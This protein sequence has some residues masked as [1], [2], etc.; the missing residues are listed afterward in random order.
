MSWQAYLGLYVILGFV[1]ARFLQKKAADSVEKDKLLVHQFLFSAILAFGFFLYAGGSFDQLWHPL[2]PAVMGLGVLNGAANHFHWKALRISL[3]KT[4]VL[5][6]FDDISA[7]AL[8]FVFLGEFRLLREPRLLLG[9][10]LCFGSAWL[11][12][13]TRQEITA[14]HNRA[15]LTNVLSYSLLWGTTS[16]AMRALALAGLPIITFLVVWY[17]VSLLTVGVIMALTNR[18]WPGLRVPLNE[19]LWAYGAGIAIFVCMALMYTVRAIAPVTVTQPIILVSEMIIPFAIGW[20]AF[21][22][23]KAFSIIEKLAVLVGFAGGL[24]L[25]FAY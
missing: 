8:S 5:T 20:Y 23:G 19:A 7:I 12:I 2:V 6:Q 25:A 15:L 17:S 21:R 18:G 9:M 13:K 22:E 3:S 11:F 16:C 1:V 4:S 10:G 14:L 24:V